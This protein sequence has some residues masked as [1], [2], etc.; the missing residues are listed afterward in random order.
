MDEFSGGRH[1]Y[2]TENTTDDDTN[3]GSRLHAE[4]R[5]VLR[6]LE[7]VA[8]TSSSSL[9]RESKPPVRVFEKDGQ[10]QFCFFDV[11]PFIGDG[12]WGPQS[13][14][15]HGSL[16][17][18]AAVKHPTWMAGKLRWDMPGN[19]SDEE[20]SAFA[21]RNL[22]GWIGRDGDALEQPKEVT[23]GLPGRETVGYIAVDEDL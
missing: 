11:M 20:E 7:T 19:G 18:Y 22:R 13:L 2:G 16:I 21:S 12:M 9:K 6:V 8:S 10:L 15:D 14:R 23:L 3:M 17:H 4:W 5:E 1:N